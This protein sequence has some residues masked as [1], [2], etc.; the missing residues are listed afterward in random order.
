[1]LVNAASV[2]NYIMLEDMDFGKYGLGGQ[3]TL[4]NMNTDSVAN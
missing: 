1:M 2:A 4:V 3:L